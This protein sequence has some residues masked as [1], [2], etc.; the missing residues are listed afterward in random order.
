[1]RRD[2]PEEEEVRRD[3]LEGQDVRRDHPEEEE[4]RRDHLEEEEVRR[5]HLEG[6]EDQEVQPVKL[7]VYS[8]LLSYCRRKYLDYQLHRLYRLL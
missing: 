1:M 6:Q 7:K 4:V 3:H 8:P 2:H 5:D